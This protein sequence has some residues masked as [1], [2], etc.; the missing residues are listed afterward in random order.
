MT[1]RIVQSGEDAGLVLRVEGWLEAQDVPELERVVD[2]SPVAGVALDLSELRAACKRG[3]QALQSFGER[4][5]VL[6]GVPHSIALQLDT[7][8]PD[9]RPRSDSG[10]GS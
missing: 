3:I 2:E 10:Q 6:R 1:I 8:L 7:E 9:P 5:V 4:G